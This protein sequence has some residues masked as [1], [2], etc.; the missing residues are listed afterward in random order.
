[1]DNTKQIL[2]T[3]FGNTHKFEYIH[4]LLISFYVFKVIVTPKES[5]PNKALDMLWECIM[6]QNFKRKIRGTYLVSEDVRKAQL[7]FAEEY[8]M[9][10]KEVA[11][12]YPELLRAVLIECAR[13]KFWRT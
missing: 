4:R 11:K 10:L 1:M 9:I 8:D 7:R 2:Y 5:S 6:H 13:R 3:W 12:L